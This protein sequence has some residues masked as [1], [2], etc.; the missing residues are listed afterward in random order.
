MLGEQEMAEETSGIDYRAVLADLLEKRAN[1]D[2]AI[3]GVEA[4]LGVS[5]IVG[6]NSSGIGDPRAP[7]VSTNTAGALLGLSITDAAKK[8]LGAQRRP[9][10]NPEIEDFFKSGGLVLNSKDWANTI[11]AVLTRRS[12]EVGDIVKIDRGTWGLK[13]WYPGR[14]FKTKGENGDKVEPETQEAPKP[15]PAKEHWKTRQK[16]LRLSETSES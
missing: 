15:Q 3:A 10:R 16:R 5:S 13:E 12:T 14:S 2:R 4:L 8:V 9:L 11:G 1:L 6:G 7:G